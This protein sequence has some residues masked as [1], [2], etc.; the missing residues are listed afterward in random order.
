[1]SGEF[2]TNPKNVQEHL[3]ERFPVHPV[4]HRQQA[5]ANLGQEGEKRTYQEDHRQRHSEPRLG[6][7]RQQCQ[8]DVY[9]MSRR[10]EKDFGYKVT[11]SG[12]DY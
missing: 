8:H 5:A 11:I 9:H 7:T 10:S 3:P 6:D 12:N 2:R 4:Q 1:M